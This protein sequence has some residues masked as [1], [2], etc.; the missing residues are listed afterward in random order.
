[1]G[2]G[3]REEREK[4]ETEDVRR[5]TEKDP[6]DRIFLLPSF[7]FRFTFLLFR[8]SAYYL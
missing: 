7:L 8:R 4:W 2:N 5:E 1:M 3:R 6:G